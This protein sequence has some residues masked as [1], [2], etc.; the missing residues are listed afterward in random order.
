MPPRPLF[1][2]LCTS[3]IQA[4]MDLQSFEAPGGR[5]S[6]EAL[7]APVSQLGLK[8]YPARTRTVISSLD[9]KKQ[10][11][12]F[13]PSR[14]P[15]SLIARLRGPFRPL[16]HPTLVCSLPPGRLLDPRSVPKSLT[17]LTDPAVT[18]VLI[19]LRQ[20]AACLVLYWLNCSR[21]FLSSFVEL[22]FLP[23]DSCLSRSI[24]PTKPSF[25][26]DLSACSPVTMSPNPQVRTHKLALLMTLALLALDA[27]R[28]D[29]HTTIL[30][31]LHCAIAT[32]SDL[33]PFA[34]FKAL[35]GNSRAM[36][37]GGFKAVKRI[38]GPVLWTHMDLLAFGGT[39]AAAT[40]SQA[41]VPANF[42]VVDPVEPHWPIGI[43]R[44]ID[45][46]ALT[47]S[48]TTLTTTLDDGCDNIARASSSDPIGNA[49]TTDARLTK[50]PL[51]DV[52]KAS[53]GNVYAAG[54]LDELIQWLEVKHDGVP[55]VSTHTIVQMGWEALAARRVACAMD[56][57][58]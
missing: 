52:E 16:S 55:L 36:P 5:F 12:P 30:A 58:Y 28:H 39:Q 45:A 37:S 6:P 26:N 54:L 51:K 8:P 24:G 27:T 4:Q 42:K 34:R 2:L 50:N 21:I 19:R 49:A 23:V 43:H 53:K 44:S 38:T 47:A 11:Q 41:D 10:S 13:A 31:Q 46:A 15:G 9:T 57:V 32:A 20:C 7:F 25:E 40:C 29:S 22:P 17:R 14:N 1:F 56:P 3:S 48:S 18:T 35:E 33:W